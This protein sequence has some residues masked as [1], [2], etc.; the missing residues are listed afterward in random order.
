MTSK[1]ALE[2]ALLDGGPGVY[3][4]QVFWHPDEPSDSEM[5]ELRDAVSAEFEQFSSFV[6]K[7]N[8]KIGGAK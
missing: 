1:Y 5:L 8:G 4:V 6:L 2:L 3:P 7:H